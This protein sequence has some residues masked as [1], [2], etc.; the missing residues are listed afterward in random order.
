[1]KYLKQ[2]VSLA[3]VGLNDAPALSAC[4]EGV[5]VSLPDVSELN[6][7][8]ASGYI[9]FKYE[10]KRLSLQNDPEQRLTAE[11][12]LCEITEVE[13]DEEVKKTDDVVD[14]L[15]AE[16]AKKEDDSDGSGDTD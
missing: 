4:S 12:C 7:L 3:P 10:R 5:Y 6:S 8:P 14:K 9:T 13:A 15:F 2:P 11:L 1:M 16:A